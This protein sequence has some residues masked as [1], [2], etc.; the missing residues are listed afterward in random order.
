VICDSVKGSG[1]AGCIERGEVGVVVGAEAADQHAGRR[2]RSFD[3]R[4]GGLEHADVLGDAARPPSVAVLLVPDLPRIDPRAKGVG[5]VVDGAGEVLIVGRW[6]RRTAR[7]ARPRWCL[8][9][10]DVNFDARGESGEERLVI[11]DLCCRVGTAAWLDRIPVD[12][13]A[14]P[15]GVQRGHVSLDRCDLGRGTEETGDVETRLCGTGRGRSD[16]H[17]HRGSECRADSSGA[18]Q[19][20]SECV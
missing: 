3:R 19:S 20:T 7:A 10:V 11:A 4:V 16:E 12:E 2:V 6:R 13:H 18:A 8:H 17:H 5:E 9:D 1:R 15:S 14:H